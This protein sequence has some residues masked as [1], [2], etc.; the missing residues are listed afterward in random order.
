MQI[1]IHQ[2]AWAANCPIMFPNLA[3]QS[4][5]FWNDCSAHKST[6]P[7]YKVISEQALP[8]YCTD[9]TRVP[10]DPRGSQRGQWHR[11][12][13]S[14]ETSGFKNRRPSP[15]SEEFCQAVEKGNS[16]GST[17]SCNERNLKKL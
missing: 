2:N 14:G 6:L 17:W 11:H 9:A 3:A 4:L 16:R 15:R 5:L 8:N 7:K 10:N 13:T 1:S 12:C